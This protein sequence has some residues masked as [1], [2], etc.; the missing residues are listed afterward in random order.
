MRRQIIINN[1]IAS[2]FFF[3]AAFLNNDVSSSFPA[4]FK[5][6]PEQY[7]GSE[8]SAKEQVARE[9]HSRIDLP[10]GFKMNY[11]ID[12]LSKDIVWKEIHK[13]ENK[14]ILKTEDELYFLLN[15]DNGVIKKEVIGPFEIAETFITV[16][17]KLYG[18]IIDHGLHAEEIH[19]IEQIIGSHFDIW[20][21]EL[22]GY[23]KVKSRVYKDHS[24]LI[25]K[26]IEFS[27]NGIEKNYRYFQSFGHHGFLDQDCHLSENE[28]LKSPV[29]FGIITS[30]YDK[31]R[32]H[33]L[34]KKKR[35]HLGTDYFT[36]VGDP[37]YSIGSGEIVKL[38]FTKNNGNYIKIKHT[39]RYQ[40]QYLHMSKFHPNL[41]VGSKVNKGQIIGFI[42]SSG[43]A[44]DPHVCFRFWKDGIQIPHLNHKVKHDRKVDENICLKL[45]NHNKKDK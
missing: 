4:S 29:R 9:I 41:Q 39:D 14:L 7:I 3:S 28:F 40:S 45:H 31:D 35:P 32:V 17:G 18:K 8:V 38:E 37:I 27:L 11:F 43:L 6:S 23:I 20:N 33:P 12:T 25:P 2:L 16:D 22:R 34:T 24:F 15:F 42:G 5:Y 36:S 10:F 19:V 30:H 1:F 13:T 44:T 21:Q 26:T